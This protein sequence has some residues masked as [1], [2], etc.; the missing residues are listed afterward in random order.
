MVL[1]REAE[2]KVRHRI[3]G[4]ER[5]LKAARMIREMCKWEGIGMEELRGGSRRGR[6]PEIRSELAVRLME[7]CGLSLAEIGEA[8]GGNDL[9]GFAD[10][11]EKGEKPLNIINNVPSPLG[12]QRARGKRKEDRD[13]VIYALWEKGLFRNE[14]IGQVFGL[15][16]SAVSHILKEVRVRIK[17]DPRMGSK[18]KRINSQFKI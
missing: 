16:Y 13:L 14:E 1:L 2:E 15:S 8:V 11:Q 5:R 6:I 10:D 18:T 12:G 4:E 17:K 9:C 7:E 3:S